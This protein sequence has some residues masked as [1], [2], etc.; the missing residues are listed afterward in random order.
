MQDWLA[1]HPRFNMHAFHADLS[2]VAQHG[3]VILPRHHYQAVASRSLHQR[4]GIDWR[5]R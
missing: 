1:K 2:I 5:H 4:A 3:R